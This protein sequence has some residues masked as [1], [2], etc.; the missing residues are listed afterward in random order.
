MARDFDGTNDNIDKSSGAGVLDV[1][2]RTIFSWIN[3]GSATSVDTI[4]AT[5]S[6]LSA[7]NIADNYGVNQTGGAFWYQYG[8]SVTAG[9]WEGTTNVLDSAWHACGADYDRGSTGNDATLYVDG[10]DDSATET[11]PPDGTAKTGLA[12]YRFGENVGGGADYNGECSHLAH[13]N[14]ALSATKQAA[15]G[16]GVNPFVM[17]ND[18]LLVYVPLHA[19]HGSTEPEYKNQ[20]NGTVSGPVKAATNPPV[21]LLEHYL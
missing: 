14:V 20:L 3:S 17:E 12:A 5:G 13:W 2:I 19:A 1:A 9:V 7:G 16:R 6:A 8:R 18:N 4:Y 10:S 11:T 15:L 21:V